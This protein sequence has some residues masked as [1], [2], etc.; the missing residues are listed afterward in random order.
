VTSSGRVTRLPW[1]EIG[2]VESR[3]VR[4][5]SDERVG[6]ILIRRRDGSAVELPA[7][8]HD[9][10]RLMRLIHS[11]PSI[12]GPAEGARKAG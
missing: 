9:L 2:W 8:L 7:D 11:P 3:L 4:S 12:P 5:A 10:D 1:G 6:R